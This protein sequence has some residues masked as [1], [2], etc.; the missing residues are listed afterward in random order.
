MTSGPGIAPGNLK[1][2]LLLVCSKP[3]L[4][5]KPALGGAFK[6]RLPEG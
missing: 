6:T 4:L 3:A 5:K 2:V 1:A